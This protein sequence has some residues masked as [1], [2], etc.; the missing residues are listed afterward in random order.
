M[1]NGTQRPDPDTLSKILSGIVHEHPQLAH[2]ILEAY[3]L[4]DIPAGAAPGGRPWAQ[5]VR[6]SVDEIGQPR[7]LEGGKVDEFEL[8]LARFNHVARTTKHGRNFLLNFDQW[9]RAGEKER[10]E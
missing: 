9:S 4:D 3:L 2:D 10:G 8:A 5:L 7:I 1:F 6:V